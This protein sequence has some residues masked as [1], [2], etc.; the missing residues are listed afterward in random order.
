MLTL[1]LLAI[2]FGVGSEPPTPRP[3]EARQ[4]QKSR[5]GQASQAPRQDE[6]G[7]AKSPLVVEVTPAPINQQELDREARERQEKAASDRKLVT[8]TTVMGLTS[9]A[10]V[11]F[12]A[13]NLWLLKRQGSDLDKQRGLMKRQA[14]YL[15]E[16]AIHLKATAAA[17]QTSARAA[18][19]TI[20]TMKEVATWQTRA[21]VTVIPNGDHNWQVTEGTMLRWM[22]LIRNTGQSPAHNVRIASRARILGVE[23]ATDDEFPD[24]ALDAAGGHGTTLAPSQEVEGMAALGPV[25]PEEFQ[26]VMRGESHIYVITAILYRDVS[27]TER[28]TLNACFYRFFQDG[29]RV[30]YSTKFHNE[31]T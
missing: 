5:P 28:K 24:V 17:A 30:K 22:S 10:L 31:A 21:Y 6:R 8:W 4:D 19:E 14:D 1:L 26:K 25:P 29:L 3:I 11:V 2:V 9:V 20:A 12:T 16:Q 13:I 15:E 7:T 27:G 23:A 18:Q